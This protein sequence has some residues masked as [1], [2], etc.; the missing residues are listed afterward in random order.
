MINVKLLD[1]VVHKTELKS[2]VSYDTGRRAADK[3]LEQSQVSTTRMV[4]A[5]WSEG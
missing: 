3:K 5:D 1:T 4:L 2:T